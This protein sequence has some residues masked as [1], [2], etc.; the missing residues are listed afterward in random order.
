MPD[1]PTLE[2]PRLLL[3]EITEADAADLLAIH[4]DA[5]HMKWF[6]TD[7]LPDLDA[8]LAVVRVFAGWRQQPNPGTRWGIS[9]KGEPGL[10]GSCGLFAWNRQ[11]RKCSLG[12]ELAPGMVGR[13]LMQEALQ[14]VI[15]WGL[16]AMNLNRIEAQVHE[17]NAASL[18]LLTRLGFVHEG[19]LRQVAFWG[20]QHHDLLQWSLLAAEWAHAP[21]NASGR[22]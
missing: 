21:A 19:R 18:A 6:G 2:T 10:V 17:R 12:Y 13:G 15:G 14:A 5:E 7:P 16:Q 8:A 20:G 22:S 3:R 4:G 1:F 9:L 11:W